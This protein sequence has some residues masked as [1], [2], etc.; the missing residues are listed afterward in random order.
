MKKAGNR[1]KS[2]SLLSLSMA[3]VLLP[4]APGRSRFHRRRG[5]RGRAVRHRL[6]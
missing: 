3:A 4:L 5:G 6:Q 1:R 2:G